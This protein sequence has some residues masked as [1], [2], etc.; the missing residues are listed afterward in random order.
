MKSAASAYGRH[1]SR[2]LHPSLNGLQF[3]LIIGKDL[4][5]RSQQCSEVGPSKQIAF[6]FENQPLELGTVRRRHRPNRK[7]TIS[8]ALYKSEHISERAE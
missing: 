7:Q 4:V 2:W 3:V 1:T 6:D 8:R 5:E